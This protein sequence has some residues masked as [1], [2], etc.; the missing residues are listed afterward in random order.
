M[1]ANASI[2]I[3]KYNL[4]LV[5]VT[6]AS[7]ISGLATALVQ[8]SLNGPKKRNILV[9]SAELAMYGIIALVL[10]LIFNSDIEPGGNILSNWNYNTMIPVITNVN[11]N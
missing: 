5:M 4:G 6:A 9:L 8:K 10:N 1:K 7:M 11:F 3:A 2:D